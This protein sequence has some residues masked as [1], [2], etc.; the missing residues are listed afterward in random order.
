[1]KLLLRHDVHVRDKSYDVSIYESKPK[2]GRKIKITYEAYNAAE[3]CTAEIWDGDKWNNMLNM[4]DLAIRPDSN[5]YFTDELNRRKRFE[6]VIL[7][8]AL[9]FIDT[10]IS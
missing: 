6:N 4:W 7:P 3:R 9:K 2:L 1:M 10:I 5:I 8:K